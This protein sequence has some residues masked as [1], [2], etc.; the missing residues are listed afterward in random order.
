MTGFFFKTGDMI[1]PVNFQRGCLIAASRRLYRLSCLYTGLLLV[2]HF[3]AGC[4]HYPVN[5]PLDHF[6]PDGGYRLERIGSP[7]NSRSL[8]VIVTFSG[9]GTRAAAFSYGV[10]EELA[11]T[12]IWWEGRQRRLLDEVDLISAVSGGSFTAAYYGLFGDRIFEEF[13]GRF[14][15]KNIQRALM[16]RVLHP[17][18][19]LRLA[20]PN[21]DRSDL[22]AEY[23]DEELFKGRTLGDIA[24]RGGPVIYINATD[25][26]LGTWF[27]FCQEQFDSICSDV[28][29]FPVARAVAASSAAP[30]VLSPVTLRNY[31]GSCGYE[32]PQ[33]VRECLE[34]RNVSR[35]R[36]QQAVHAT[37]YTDVQ[38]RPYVHLLD[39][40][41]ADNLGL[42]AIMDRIIF[43]RDPWST[44][45]MAGL[46]ETGRV[47]FI[48]VNAEIEPDIRLDQQEK[49]P[50]FAQVIKTT[51][52][53]SIKRYNFETVELLREN[54]GKWAKE[55]RTRRCAAR[56]V[57][58]EAEDTSQVGPWND[59]ACY[60]VEVNLDA[61]PDES[62]RSHLKGLP[63]TFKLRP[64][65]VDHLR[66]A[67]HRI[68]AQSVE[69]QRLLRDLR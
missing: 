12:E 30:A 51:P 59:I 53:V 42:R 9:G 44:L 68:L 16:A 61:L 20:S 13:E 3:V 57:E 34:E 62:E 31:A 27:S 8:L 36:F 45:Q 38:K 5:Q 39:G 4:A 23:Y 49:A 64:E 22:A 6:N 55:I 19:W 56:S 40:G 25:M 46:E 28:S 2:V 63:S 50:R 52:R 69:F 65:T 60:L 18:N 43:V 10:L 35:R 66:D 48:V 24:A 58:S 17:L 26:T 37:S 21:F 1:S 7:G 54:L 15:K 67:A 33:Y 32:I 41:L 47:V 29:R 14:L 11:G